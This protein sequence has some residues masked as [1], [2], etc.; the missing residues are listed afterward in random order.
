MSIS[1]LVTF[2]LSSISACGAYTAYNYC[3][4]ICNTPVPQQTKLIEGNLVTKCTSYYSES[5][6]ILTHNMEGCQVVHKV[7]IIFFVKLLQFIQ[8]MGSYMFKK[9]QQINVFFKKQTRLKL[10][11]ILAPCSMIHFVYLYFL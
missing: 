6:T 5:Y 10:E 4:S 11:S 3:S 1:F 7:M 8:N 2:T 9:K